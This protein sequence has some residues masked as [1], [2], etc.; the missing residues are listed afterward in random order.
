MSSH[1][2]I[3]WLHKLGVLEMCVII[4]ECAFTLKEK[5]DLTDVY[6]EL[7]TGVHLVRLLELISGEKLPTSSRRS[8][9]VHS[10]ENNSIAINFLK[11]KIRVDLIGPENIVDG[12]RTLILGLI[13]IIILLFQIGAINIVEWRSAKEALL[14]WCQHKTAGYANVNVQDFS[15]SWRDGLAF[16]A[17]IHEHNLTEPHPCFTLAEDEF[18]IM[19]LLDVEDVMHLVSAFK[20][21]RTIEK[22]PKYQERG[23]IEAHLFNLRTKLRGNNQWD[24]IPLEGK[25]LGDIERNWTLLERAEHQRER[26]LQSAL[27]R[28]EQLEQLAQKFGHKATLRESYLEDIL[29]LIQQQD[30]EG[31]QRLE[32]AE[33]VARKLEAL[34]ADVLAHEPRF[35]TLSE[36]AVVIEKENYHSKAQWKRH[37]KN[38]FLVKTFPLMLAL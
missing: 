5:V 35:R 8:L 30:L 16:N 36:M 34:G 11:T 13:W 19:Q 27:M 4:F 1:F 9:R 28:L 37:V 33:T 14:I 32:E 20:M 18:G 17:L 15:S 38:T 3:I 6:T 31:L 2:M 22:P 7:R 23:A 24:Y 29:Q 10:L 12:D 21:Y 25:T 26:D